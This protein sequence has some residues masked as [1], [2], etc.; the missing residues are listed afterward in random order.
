ML[1]LSPK[2]FQIESEPVALATE[3]FD[4]TLL[5]FWP[6]PSSNFRSSVRET[7]DP[8][9]KLLDDVVAV[10]ELLQE[11]DQLPFAVLDFM[12]KAASL[13]RESRLAIGALPS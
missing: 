1:V 13:G 6:L 9:Y 4:K 3:S 2:L 11:I 8:V 12:A 5:I 7:E 10:A